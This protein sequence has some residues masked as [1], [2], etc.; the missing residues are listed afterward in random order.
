MTTT[1]VNFADTA[2]GWQRAIYAFLVEKEQRSG[3]YRTVKGYSQMLQNFFGRLGKEPDKVSSPDIFAYA[4]GPGLS[5][6]QTSAITISARIACLSSF[7]RFLIRMDLVQSNPC[8]KLERSQVSP[9]PPRGLSAEQ[10][11]KLLAATPNTPVGLRDR[12]IILTL[13]LTGRRR[14]EVLGMKAGDLSIEG[15]RAYYTYRGKGGKRG[16]RELPQ[17]ALDAIRAGLAAFGR[18]MATM[19]RRKEPLWPSCSGNS[20]G[21]TSG[22]FYGNLQR[23]FRLADMKSAGVHIFRHTA[24]KLRRDAGQS[25]EEVSQFLDHSSLAVTTVY[26]RRLEGERDQG[27][28]KVAQAIGV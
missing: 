23:Y 22:T 15:E 20:K 1:I 14:A 19:A 5:G 17:P 7:Y 13:V 26:L 9:S 16:R 3:S 2:T 27:W 10:V 4:H 18:D 25:V 21:L 11:Q 12:A 6:K 28:V 24:A 8:D